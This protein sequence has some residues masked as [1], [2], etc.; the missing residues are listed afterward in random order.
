MACANC[1][2]RAAIATPETAAVP[3]T[4]VLT[5]CRACV[6]TRLALLWIVGFGGAWL[7][8]I[9]WLVGFG[10]CGCAP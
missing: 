5:S 9:Y 7:G 6:R 4:P 10:P 3:L 1:G 2:Q 8:A